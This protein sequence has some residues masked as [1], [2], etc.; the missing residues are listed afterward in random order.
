MLLRKN[1]R[2]LAAIER[3]GAM[4]STTLT[5]RVFLLAAIASADGSV[6]QPKLPDASAIVRS[7]RERCDAHG[8]DAVVFLLDEHLFGETQTSTTALFVDPGPPKPPDPKAAN[9][10]IRALHD[11]FDRGKTPAFVGRRAEPTRAIPRARGA[12]ANSI[13]DDPTTPDCRDGVAWAEKCA[14]RVQETFAKRSALVLVT[15]RP[16]RVTWTRE[17]ESAARDGCWSP[18]WHEEEVG[19]TLAKCGAELIVVAPEAA[20]GEDTPVS[21]APFLPWASRPVAAGRGQVLA[22]LA[23]PR[24]PDPGTSDLTPAQRLEETVKAWPRFEGQL[25]EKLDKVD[26]PRP[27]F[28]RSLESDIPSGFVAWEYARAC[29]ITRGACWFFPRSRT[30][31]LDPCKRGDLARTLIPDVD[32][33]AA[34]QWKARHDDPLDATTRRISGRLLE[35][36]AKVVKAQPIFPYSELPTLLRHLRGREGLVAPFQL[37]ADATPEELELRR[38]RDF[39]KTLP[40]LIAEYDAGADELAATLAALPPELLA[41]PRR[42]RTVADAVLTLYWLRT[43]AFHLAQL[44]EVVGHPEEVLLAP[45]ENVPYSIVSYEC[46]RMSELLGAY[47]G[48]SVDS[49]TDATYSARRTSDLDAFGEQRMRDSRLPVDPLDPLFRAARYPPFAMR[50]LSP[51]ARERLLRIFLHATRLH[52]RFAQTPWDW[53]VYYDE[54]QSFAFSSRW[55]PLPPNP[56][57]GEPTT[58]LPP[59]IDVTPKQPPVDTTPDP[60]G[61]P[62]SGG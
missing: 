29:R 61:P 23:E 1:E 60:L 24:S 41:D 54:L 19:R 42:T 21:L 27:D 33:S 40:P 4:V 38:W 47:D 7:I 30:E 10:W 3:S 36:S 16:P 51:A 35:R 55:C 43:S 39:A 5:G 50:L 13:Q 44:E 22:F 8:L 28:H 45:K 57:P 62:T 31:W 18:T 26:P 15:D 6:F 53:M 46:V 58:K 17:P 34:A 11:S 25:P 20:F 2:G 59:P 14:G 56:P 52:E 32:L 48:A 49:D 37:L 9:E 12:S